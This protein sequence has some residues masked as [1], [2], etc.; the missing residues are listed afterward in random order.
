MLVK[1]LA[2]SENRSRLGDDLRYVIVE[3]VILKQ[4]FQPGLESYGPSI[5]SCHRRVQL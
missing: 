5:A 4:R 2:T 1:L 3:Y